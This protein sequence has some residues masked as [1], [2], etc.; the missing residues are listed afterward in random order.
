METL[1]LRIEEEVLWECS[2]E[3]DGMT[4]AVCEG[5]I[6]NAL[7]AAPGVK[8]AAVSNLL[9][10][11]DVT[12]SHSEGAVGANYL[13]DIIENVGFDVKISRLKRGRAP[14]APPSSSPTANR[15]SGKFIEEVAQ[16]FPARVIL[17]LFRCS[18]KSAS[19]QKGA[20]VDHL[21]KLKGVTRVDELTA[22]L[23]KS[24]KKKALTFVLLEVRLDLS[25]SKLRR[26][27]D[28]CTMAGWSAEVEEAFELVEEDREVPLLA[29][30][31][32]SK[33][34][35]SAMKLHDAEL[36]MWWNG[37]LF[38]AALAIPCFILSMV[39]PLINN[40]IL[41][42][43]GF[44]F[45]VKGLWTRDCV[46]AA[47]A[48]PVQFW[49]GAR[50]YRGAWAGIKG[51]LAL[52]CMTRDVAERTRRWSILCRF[53]L[54][55]DFLIALGTTV[56]YLSSIL[57]MILAVLDYARLDLLLSQGV[58]DS[59]HTSTEDMGMGGMGTAGM[60]QKGL[61]T[62]PV[63]VFFDTS[64][65]LIAFVMLGKTLESFAKGKTGAAL[66]SLVKLQPSEAVILVE[67]P[68]EAEFWREFTTTRVKIDGMD[69]GEMNNKL[70]ASSHVPVTALPR[71]IP[72]CLLAPG[73]LVLVRPGSSIPCDGVVE[74]G[75]SEVDESMLT[76]EAW[77]VYKGPGVS[78]TGAT[79]NKG[80]VL[81]VRASR[82]GGRSTLAQILS[83]VQQA[84]MSKAPIQKFADKISGWFVPAVVIMSI[85]TYI[86]WHSI[87]SS[88]RLDS[89]HDSSG[90]G[91]SN[92]VLALRFAVAVVVVACPC[93]LGLATPT[94]IMVGTGVGA[95]G[96]V[97]IKGGECLE[98]AS[99]CSAIIFDK[100]GTLTAGVPEL[101]LLTFL[102]QMQIRSS[103]AGQMPQTPFLSQLQCLSLISS[104]EALSEHPLGQAI[105]TGAKE[106]GKTMLSSPSSEAPRF[107]S[108]LPMIDVDSSAWQAL[109]GCGLKCT[110]STVDCPSF[111]ALFKD[112]CVEKSETHFSKV[113]V[114]IGTCSWFE[115][116]GLLVPLLAKLVQKRCEL[117]GRTSVLVAFNG[118][119]QV[120]C[121]LTDQVKP[122]AAEIV[123][124]L[125]QPVSSGFLPRLFSGMGGGGRK[126]LEVWMVTGDAPRT[127]LTVASQV[128][129]PASRV[130]AGALPSDKA[131][132]V[133]DLQGRGFSVAMVGDGI[134]DTIAL[135]AADVGIAIGAGSQVAIDCAD[136]VLLGN[137]LGD[138]VFCLELS[139]AVMSRIIQ[140][141]VWALGYN[142][143]G[144]PIA[145]GVLFPVI[146]MPLAP[147]AAGLAMAMS[148]VSV[149]VSSLFLRVFKKTKF[150]GELASPSLY[151]QP[152]AEESLP[153]TAHPPQ[154]TQVATR[155]SSPHVI[156]H[157]NMQLSCACTCES[158]DSNVLTTIKG[159]TR[160]LKGLS[161]SSPPA[162]SPTLL[163]RE[164][165]CSTASESLPLT[166]PLS[167]EEEVSRMQLL[168]LIDKMEGAQEA[169][170]APDCPCCA[171]A[172]VGI[173]S[174]DILN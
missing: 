153:L 69:G 124:Y 131:T 147:E 78:V 39:V 4:C 105:Y 81:K 15:K 144:I 16:P 155:V 30:G 115:K 173:S 66:T 46:L 127:A 68:R 94:A 92:F 171:K 128:G 44:A 47:L 31:E 99:R 32:S 146:R 108:E 55:M 48:A 162:K 25:R 79:V 37:F 19:L 17:K 152:R 75:E 22:A 33:E 163:E 7:I 142:I 26:L 166:S 101:V 117:R 6:Q 112:G 87:L 169:L 120:V 149:V 62:R 121:S 21:M 116:Q 137:K 135:T 158:C 172:F 58:M 28:A 100:T 103:G 168:D 76:G 151:P 5:T 90:D 40:D 85:L 63:D 54:G 8:N 150:G 67:D 161:I 14:A 49:V 119:V 43:W 145:A 125:S 18:S 134:N 157:S 133:K 95:K 74:E 70:D 111:H 132:V 53:T 110:V 60:S 84:Q 140:N 13:K 141:F 96:G 97:L 38:S 89:I 71:S 35:E 123:K 80:G 51:H 93:A 88:G 154:L 104:V 10:R 52:P 109:P 160:S 64:A 164:T 170:R 3:V 9:R 11:A 27:V 61:R 1:T 130:V 20:L 114:L 42:K 36:K 2:Y 126:P 86:I 118:F 156:D 59:T 107:F 77:P 148:S 91:S 72:L 102:P 23:S 12:F 45:G 174:A 159:L 136:V 106:V 167:E 56:S 165:C 29:G 98:K 34:L 50:F 65:L 143:L 83:L 57:E 41:V 113:E 82:V 138:I 122:D 139:R 129:I 24:G 73:D